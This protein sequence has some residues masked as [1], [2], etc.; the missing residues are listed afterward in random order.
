MRTMI[1]FY[2]APLAV[3][4]AVRRFVLKCAGVNERRAAWAVVAKKR[5]PAGPIDIAP[6]QSPTYKR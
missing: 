1:A 3:P 2:V 4:L 6:G 5:Y